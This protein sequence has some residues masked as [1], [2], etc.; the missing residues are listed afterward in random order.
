[1]VS[2]N[3]EQFWCWINLWWENNLVCSCFCIMKQPEQEWFEGQNV[4]GAR[5]DW[6][7]ELFYPGWHH[8]LLLELQCLAWHGCALCQ[9]TAPCTHVQCGYHSG[10][11]L[12]SWAS[13]P[14]QPCWLSSVVG[15]L[16]FCWSWNWDSVPAIWEYPRSAGE[17]GCRKNTR[18]ITS[19]ILH[20]L[21]W[22]RNY[23]D[24]LAQQFS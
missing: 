16:L 20:R 19:D 9:Q 23:R 14:D 2:S 15:K 22:G 10:K 1:M 4:R 17:V 5:L 7:G 12:E 11:W 21:T 18:E 3:W 6:F 8:L 24:G 13:S